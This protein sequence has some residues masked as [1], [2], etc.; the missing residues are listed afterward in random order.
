M[1]CG[2]TVP[3]NS[4]HCKTCVR[5]YCSHEHREKNHNEYPKHCTGIIVQLMIEVEKV[6]HL[7][8]KKGFPVYKNQSIFPLVGPISGKLPH[9][10]YPIDR[11]PGK[12]IWNEITNGR[13]PDGDICYLVP[14]DELW[15]VFWIQFNNDQRQQVA[16]I[17]EK[18]AM[19]SFNIGFAPNKPITPKPKT[20]QQSL[21]KST[22]EIKKEE[23]KDDQ[24]KSN[25]NSM[26]MT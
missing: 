13:K 14:I 12:R 26:D 23:K 22:T 5:I 20:Q 10:C 21:S 18:N 15:R 8:E 16:D 25:N 6:F 24:P 7:K 1:E 2:I 3:D 19:R 11:D 4:I 17:T 9:S